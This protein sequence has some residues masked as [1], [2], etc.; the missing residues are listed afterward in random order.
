VFFL[1]ACA[2]PE[3]GKESEEEGEL[4][5]KN[6]IRFY[7]KFTFRKK[8]G[9]RSEKRARKASCELGTQ[10]SRAW[11]ASRCN[12]IVA[13]ASIMYLPSLVMRVKLGWE[14]SLGTDSWKKILLRI[15]WTINSNFLLF[16]LRL[17]RGGVLMSLLFGMSVNILIQL[18]PDDNKQNFFL[19]IDILTTN[20]IKETDTK[21][22]EV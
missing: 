14:G 4:M 13:K 6:S 12:G 15:Q 20:W 19:R 9:A 11:R 1:L 5:K 16:P 22:K 2:P 18:R 8:R 3:E 17:R 21:A 7:R 10:D